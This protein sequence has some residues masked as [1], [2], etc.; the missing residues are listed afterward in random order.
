MVF[1]PLAPVRGRFPG[2]PLTRV[3]VT[4]ARAVVDVA[5]SV[6]LPTTLVDGVDDVDTIDDVEVVDPST[7]VVVVE[8]G[9]V[10]DVDDDVVVLVEVVDV[11]VVVD[12]AVVVLGRVEAA[13]GDR[14]RGAGRPGGRIEIRRDGERSVIGDGDVAVTFSHAGGED[15]SPPAREPLPPPPLRPF[16]EP[17]EPP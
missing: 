6:V 10:V 17:P 14:D 3:V 13:A 9:E 4:P 12:G 16:V 7:L 5:G 2:P 11:V 8:L 15:A 1:Q